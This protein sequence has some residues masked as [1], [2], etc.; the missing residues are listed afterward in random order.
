MAENMQTL[1]VTRTNYF[2]QHSTKCMYTASNSAVRVIHSH[3]GPS[4]QSSFAN[5]YSTNI[6]I[7]LWQLEHKTI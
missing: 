7:N 6:Y 3:N 4:Y 2:R 1:T 5:I